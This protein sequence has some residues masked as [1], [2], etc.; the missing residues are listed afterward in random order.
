MYTLIDSYNTIYRFDDCRK[1]VEHIQQIYID[2]DICMSEILASIEV[3]GLSIE[4]QTELYMELRNWTGD[5]ISM[6]DEEGNFVL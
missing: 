2:D 5:S 3:Q 4:A 1:L 6:V